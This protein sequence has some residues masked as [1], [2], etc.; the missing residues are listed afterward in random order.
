MRLLL[1]E[2]LSPGIALRSRKLGVD[3]KSIHEVGR[4]GLG[5]RD[6]LEYAAA[7]GRCFV[8]R[9]RNDYLL[10]TREFFEKGRPHCGVLIVPWTL[11]PDK[12][13][14]I[15]RALRRYVNRYGS[16]PSEYLFDFLSG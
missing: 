5:D 12:L 8:T 6:Q 3:A 9:N 15:A 13:T 14:L 7:Q 2:D 10:L 11:A 4:R 1:D 16:S